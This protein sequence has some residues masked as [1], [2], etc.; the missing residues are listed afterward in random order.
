MQSNEHKI[1]N[2]NKLKVA[3]VM[4]LQKIDFSNQNVINLIQLSPA[5]N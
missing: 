5:W 3:V 4:L 1:V 2:L